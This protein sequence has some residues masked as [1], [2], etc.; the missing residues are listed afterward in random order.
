[1]QL[2]AGLSVQRDGKPLLECDT[3]AI[4]RLP[5][6]APAN[7][8][9]DIHASDAGQLTLHTGTES[10]PPARVNGREV[11]AA[12]GRDAAVVYRW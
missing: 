5:L 12:G 9:A 2:D 6:H 8:P 4:I 11:Q 10:A 1:M 7:T 3:R